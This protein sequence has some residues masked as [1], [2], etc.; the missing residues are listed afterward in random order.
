MAGARGR[1]PALQ[2]TSVPV[3]G[4]AIRRAV[5]GRSPLPFRLRYASHAWG[6]GKLYLWGG[7]NGNP[8]TSRPTTRVQAVG[9]RRPRQVPQ[10]RAGSLAPWSL[11]ARNLWCLVV[12]L[13]TPTPAPRL[14]RLR[15]S[16]RP[17]T[18]GNRYR[19]S[20]WIRSSRGSR[21]PSRGSTPQDSATMRRATGPRCLSSMRI[22]GLGVNTAPR[23]RAS[24]PTRV[25]P[26]VRPQC[27]RQPPPPSLRQECLHLHVG[28]SQDRPQCSFRHVLG[29]MRN[30]D[31]APVCWAAPHLVAAWT[32]AIKPKAKSSQSPDY[33]LVPEPAEPS[34]RV[35]RQAE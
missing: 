8:L 22:R 29:V 7:A 10:A 25:P 31:L 12:H 1:G 5:G 6:D 16:T 2:P 20:P 14:A 33:L 15:H 4:T 3:Q 28:L 17:R 11:S 35:T 23:R 18:P 13:G 9:R 26:I 34:H 27:P 30:R 21:R 24:T 32:W 19:R